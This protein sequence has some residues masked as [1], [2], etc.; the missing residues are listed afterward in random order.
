MVIATP[1]SVWL[2]NNWLDDFAYRIH[3]TW[4]MFA[5]VGAV[6]L[7]VALMTVG[8]QAWRAATANPVESLRM[9]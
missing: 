9:E 5:A 3:M 6:A 2:M 7:A 4:W 1:V 8:I